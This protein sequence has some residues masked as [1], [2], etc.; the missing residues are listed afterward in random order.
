[1]RA[2]IR[3]SGEDIDTR[4]FFYHGSDFAMSADGRYFV[5]RKNGDASGKSWWRETYPTPA[6]KVEMDNFV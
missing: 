3:V 5:N 2:K 4:T 6:E 1:M